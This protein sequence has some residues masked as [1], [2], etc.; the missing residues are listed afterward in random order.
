MVLAAMAGPVVSFGG[1]TCGLSPHR[2]SQAS[3]NF[4]TEVAENHGVPQRKPSM[5][6]RAK[7]G[8]R[9]SKQDRAAGC[10]V[11]V[12][13]NLGRPFVLPECSP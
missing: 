10:R 8:V 13:T 4:D 11:R 1:E 2:S 9:G 7:R 12:A 5:A 3:R 6:L